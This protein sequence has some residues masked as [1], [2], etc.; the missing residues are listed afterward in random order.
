MVFL[1]FC[2]YS[3]PMFFNALAKE[4]VNK[5]YKNSIK[6]II[7]VNIFAWAIF[8]FGELIHSGM[9]QTGL[10]VFYVTLFF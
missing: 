8:V 6:K 5:E 10:S 7:Y 9:M 1:L 3:M 2:V 4:V